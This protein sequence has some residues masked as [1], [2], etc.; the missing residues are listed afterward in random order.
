[1]FFFS[2]SRGAY[3]SIVAPMQA[4][5]WS[6][7]RFM[8]KIGQHQHPKLVVSELHESEVHY[9]FFKENDFRLVTNCAELGGHL[10]WMH[11]KGVEFHMYEV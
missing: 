1:M 7:K 11:P 10:P 3:G 2:R 5:Q 6:C 9:S 8:T 4:G